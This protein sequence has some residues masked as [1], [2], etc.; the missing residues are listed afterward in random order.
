MRGR[1]RRTRTANTREPSS[2]CCATHDVICLPP[3][4][5]TDKSLTHPLLDPGDSIYYQTGNFH[6]LIPDHAYKKKKKSFSDSVY[7]CEG[8]STIADINRHHLPDDIN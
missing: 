7:A 4:A 2:T 3:G 1:E 8:T 5:T 6:F